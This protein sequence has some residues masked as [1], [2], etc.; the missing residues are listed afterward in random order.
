[1]LLGCPQTSHAYRFC[2]ITRPARPS[3][4][5]GP[6]PMPP[7]LPA[8][9]RP[10][11]L[12]R[13]AVPGAVPEPQHHHLPAWVRR[14][15]SQARPILADMLG[16]LSGDRRDRLATALDEVTAE[17]S[18]GR[19][20]QAFR[21][22][23]LIAEGE[24]LVAEQRIESEAAERAQRVIETAR[25]RVADRLRDAATILSPDV[26]SRLGKALRSAADEEA[27]A[28]VEREV[29][30]ALET[31]RTQHDRRREREISKTRTR[32]E[33]AVPRSGGG[34]AEDW[35]DVLRR[36]QEE[37]ATGSTS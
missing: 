37:M 12:Q 15:H 9:V 27:I 24:R 28:A 3:R 36:L 7:G 30:V 18:A 8:M 22:A 13:A 10:E 2:V 35:Q 4:P 1:M 11:G 20:S 25:R 31:A 6:A 5:H 16:V 34:M 19:F 21:Y 29:S 17:I 23:D 14:A 26:S 33:R 32:I